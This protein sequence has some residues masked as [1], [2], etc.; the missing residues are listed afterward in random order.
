MRCRVLALF[1]CIVAAA[2]AAALP[3]TAIRVALGP[4]FPMSDLSNED[5]TQGWTGAQNTGGMV[6]LSIRY[7]LQEV[8]H[9][10]PEVSFYRFGRFE[11]VDRSEDPPLSWSRRAVMG[12]FRVHLDYIPADDVSRWTPFITS[13]LG[14]AFLRYADDI[15]GSDENDRSESTVGATATVG[16]GVWFP[17]MEIL[18][19][20]SLQEPRFDEVGQAS[21]TTVDLT[22][23]F[24]LPFRL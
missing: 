11:G 16:L 8:V 2:P 10:R 5:G 21:W 14:L 4:T 12:A 7:A 24:A 22:V 17:F 23:S 15:E 19:A 13:G 20:G 1:V 3:A 6:A 18:L 9:I